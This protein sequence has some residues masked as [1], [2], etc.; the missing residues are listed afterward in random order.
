MTDRS[1]AYLLGRL[2]VLEQRVR[3]AV[4]RRRA[5]DPEPDDPVR[6]L[7]VSTDQVADLLRGGPL[8]LGLP[9][10]DAERLEALEDE[11]D[12]AEAA[13]EDVRLR[14]LRRTF[15]LGAIDIELL[16][17]ALAPDLDRRYEKLYG[18]LHDDITRRRAS[19]GLALELVGLTPTAVSGRQRL[20]PDGRLV[21]GGLLDIEDVDRPY[22]TRALRV[23]DRVT[24]F[25]LGDD[26]PDPSISGL[27]SDPSAAVELPGARTVSG[28]LRAGAG[29]CY[30]RE[31]SALDGRPLVAAALRA[32]D[33]DALHLDLD[34]IEPESDALALARAAVREA[35][36]DDV[37]LVAGPV[38]GLADEVPAAVRALADAPLQVILCGGTAWDPGWS[39]RVPLQVEAPELTGQVRDGIWRGALAGA[40]GDDPDV[41]AL[42]AFHVTPRQAHRAVAS[43]RWQARAAGR[44]MTPDDLA[45]GAREQNAGRLEHLARRIEPRAAF[46]DLVLPTRTVGLL[47]EIID[48]A[49]H[50][51]RV[52]DEWRMGGQTG[53]GRGVTALFAGESGTGKTLSAEVIAGALGLDLYTIDLSTVVD[54]YVGETEKNLERIFAEAEGVNGVLFFD[55]ADA[56][57]GKR[58]DV[59]DARDRYANVEI[60]FLLQRME[61]FDGIAILATNLRG[62]LDEAFTRRI[63]VLA[64]FPEPEEPDRLRLWEL[65]LPDSLPTADEL[66]LDYLAKA[67]ELSGGDI[68]NVTLAAAYAAA[69]DEE[70]LSTRHLVRATAREYRKL[71]RLCTESEFGPYFDLIDPRPGGGAHADP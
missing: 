71:G 22:L 39:E 48:R 20:S 40:S 56:L 58:S 26:D 54:K 33:R 38:D 15:E 19:I 64:D 5:D 55:E 11:V 3:T 61:Y 65:H 41:A 42:S 13:G 45:A 1:L 8:V 59:S 27:L 67:F 62:N 63:D 6:G 31:R 30:V 68:R 24:G 23:P 16:L 36:L 29:L 49:R 21:D 52:L 10:A 43:A 47:R 17:A 53:R 34:R 70:P 50:R 32:I 66:D 18:Y 57:F 51:D 46:D 25:L 44:Q 37:T 35:R 7:Y 9:R 12:A 28:A 60:A 4:A 2:D 69:V 14:R